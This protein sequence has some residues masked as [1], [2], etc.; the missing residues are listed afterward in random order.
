[1]LKIDTNY[2]FVKV[3][4]VFFEKNEILAGKMNFLETKRQRFSCLSKKVFSH[5][6]LLCYHY[7]KVTIL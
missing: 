1:M 4:R 2:S 7:V 5:F 6:N 3:C